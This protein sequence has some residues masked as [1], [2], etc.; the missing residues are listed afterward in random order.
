MAALLGTTLEKRLSS[1]LLKFGEG[2]DALPQ[3]T[4]ALERKKPGERRSPGAMAR[5]AVEQMPGK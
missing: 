1:R 4:V 3:R 2:R 5:V